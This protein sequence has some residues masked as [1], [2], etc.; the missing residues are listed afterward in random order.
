VEDR[1]MEKEASIEY[2][3]DL[4]NSQKYWR[5]HEVL[6]AIWKNSE[7]TEKRI[8][9]SIILISAALVHYQKDEI[10]TCISILRR[11]LFKLDNIEGTYFGI[12]LHNIKDKVSKIIETGVVEKLTI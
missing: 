4:F 9:N 6:E 12:D 11:A 3:R 8:L 2:A 1:Y 7:N 10:D 5:T